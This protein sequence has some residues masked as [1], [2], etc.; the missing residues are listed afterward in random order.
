MA[1]LY[2]YI[3]IHTVCIV[4]HDSDMDVSMST[5]SWQWGVQCEFVIVIYVW[6]YIIDFAETIYLL[7]YK[8]NIYIIEIVN[9]FVIPAITSR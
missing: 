6:K 1:K 2:I 5:S 8:V 4:C 9:V 3:Y 7:Q